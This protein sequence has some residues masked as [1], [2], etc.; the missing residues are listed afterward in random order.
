MMPTRKSTTTFINIT[1]YGSAGGRNS[2]DKET[3]QNRN[4]P[5][6]CYIFGGRLILSRYKGRS[7]NQKSSGQFILPLS[8]ILVVVV[9]VPPSNAETSAPEPF[10]LNR[11]PAADTGTYILFYGTRSACSSKKRTK[12]W[13][14]FFR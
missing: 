9:C 3:S 7:V 10:S 6:D 1:P 8:M 11:S 4:A 14:F 5:P 2:N 12:P 13:S